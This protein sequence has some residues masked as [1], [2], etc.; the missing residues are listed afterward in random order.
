MSTKDLATHTRTSELGLSEEGNE[1][2]VLLL[3]SLLS[4][5]ADVVSGESLVLAQGRSEPESVEEDEDVADSER[6]WAGATLAALVAGSSPAGS[7]VGK[8]ASGTWIPLWSRTALGHTA[9]DSAH[10]IGC[11]MSA[12]AGK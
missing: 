5:T 3:L 10:G 1:E 6:S 4:T 8:E 9:N 2:I 11:A 7:S 12:C